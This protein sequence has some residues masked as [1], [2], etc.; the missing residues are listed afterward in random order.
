MSYLFNLPS[1][2]ILSIIK[3]YLMASFGITSDS[4]FQKPKI[5]MNVALYL[6]EW[7][8]GPGSYFSQENK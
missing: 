6:I 7:A 1:I 2:K 4:R 3:I 5:G 8:P